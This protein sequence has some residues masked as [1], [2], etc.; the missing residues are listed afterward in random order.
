VAI[1]IKKEEDISVFIQFTIEN[2]DMQ[3]EVSFQLVMEKT[4]M[5]YPINILRNVALEA[6]QSDCFVALDV[7]LIPLPANCYSHQIMPRLQEAGL[8]NTIFVLPAFWLLREEGEN[9]ADPDR[10]PL[11]RPD[12]VVM[13]RNSTLEQFWKNGSSRGHGF[14]QYDKWRKGKTDNEDYYEISLKKGPSKRYEPY[15]LGYKPGIP[16]YWEVNLEQWLFASPNMLT[17]LTLSPP[18]STDFR[19]FHKNK[20][21]FFT[22]CYNAGYTYAVLYDF[23]CVHIDH[24]KDSKDAQMEM[25]NNFWDKFNDD[26]IVHNYRNSLSQN[27]WI[28]YR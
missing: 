14:T 10:L 19:G 22:E 3:E 12:A 1:Y 24:S 9:F 17:T 13:E 21:S 8:R 26:Y 15:V 20:I 5:L 6:I 11:T 2:Q 23:Y 7:E 25:N 16:R 18:S 4:D 27:K 28:W